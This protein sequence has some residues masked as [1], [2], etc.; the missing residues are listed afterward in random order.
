[1]SQCG[2]G[3][4]HPSQSGQ[5]W[6]GGGG[7]GMVECQVWTYYTPGEGVLIF[8]GSEDTELTPRQTRVVGSEVGVIYN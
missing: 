8:Q 5:L 6:W 3:W 7:W 1:M 2:A 4:R